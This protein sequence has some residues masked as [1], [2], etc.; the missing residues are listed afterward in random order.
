M[1]AQE[2]TGKSK[3]NSTDHSKVQAKLRESPIKARAKVVSR[4]VSVVVSSVL[5][6]FELSSQKAREKLARIQF[7]SFDLSFCLVFF[8]QSSSKARQ[9]LAQSS[10][11]T[12]WAGA[13][14]VSLAPWVSL[15]LS[16]EPVSFAWTLPWTFEF[17][18]DLPGERWVLVGLLKRVWTFFYF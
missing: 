1:E 6:Y 2:S 15:E 14:L 16:F 10:P 18:L 11:K 13:S 8:Y 9:K 3:A 17:C 4:G 7:L 5:V 12:R